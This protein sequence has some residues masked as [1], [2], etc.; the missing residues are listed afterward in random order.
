M[1]KAL[2]H[3]LA[4]FPLTLPFQLSTPHGILCH[5]SDTALCELEEAPCVGTCL[6]TA[7]PSDQEERGQDGQCHRPADTLGLL[8]HV[9][10][11]EGPPAFQC[12]HRTFPP[13]RHAYILRIA[14]ALASVR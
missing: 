11:P 12:L 13:Q 8:G 5:L 4:L 2:R 3:I 14:P 6:V 10:L 7:I 1:I 9:H